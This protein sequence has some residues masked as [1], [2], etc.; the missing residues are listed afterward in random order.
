MSKTLHSLDTSFVIRILT[1]DPPHLFE[2]ASKFIGERGI[3]A[4]PMEVCD[5]VLAEAYFA[6]LHHYGFSKPDALAAI[7]SFSRHPAIA[8]SDYAQTAL[9]LPGIATANPGFVDRLIHGFSRS[10]GRV[11]V[12]FEKAARTLPETLVLG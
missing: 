10:A 12:T 1:G 5:L 8:V 3:D 7:L 11:M 9:A 4:P 6:L 2:S